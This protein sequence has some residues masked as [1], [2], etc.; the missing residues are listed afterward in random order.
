MSTYLRLCKLA[1]ENYR[2][3]ELQLQ[4]MFD[5]LFEFESAKKGETVKQVSKSPVDL[6]GDSSFEDEAEVMEALEQ[7]HA[8]TSREEWERMQ[9]RNRM[10]VANRTTS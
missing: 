6:F 4:F 5:R 10:K 8:H 3:P 7:P 1:E 9:I 2:T